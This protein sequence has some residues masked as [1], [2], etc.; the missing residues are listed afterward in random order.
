[1]ANVMVNGGGLPEAWGDTTAVATKPKAIGWVKMAPDVLR[2]MT[3]AANHAGRTTSEVWAEAAREWLL[4]KALEADYDVL[5]HMP[6]RKRPEDAQ[7]E[8]KRTRLWG[9][10]DSMMAGIRTD[11]VAI[12]LAEAEPR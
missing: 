10:I 12:T 3:L 6:A 9:N 7:I 11:D 4:R 2:A 1:M 8:A 5:A